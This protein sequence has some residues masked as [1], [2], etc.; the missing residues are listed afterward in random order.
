MRTLLAL[1]A[2]LVAAP[3]LRAAV[4]VRVSPEN[5]VDVQATNAPLSEILD[6]MARQ[7]KIK[8]VYEGPPPRQLLTVD[9]KDRTPAEAFLAVV[10]GQ[11]LAY[12]FAMDKSGTKVE[13]LLMAGGNNAPNANAGP[14]RSPARP[15]RPIRESVVEEPPPSEDAA[16]E[17]EEDEAPPDAAGRPVPPHGRQAEPPPPTQGVYIPVPGADFPSSVF[18]PRP[19]EADTNKPAPKPESTPPPFNP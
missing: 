14:P 17:G 9:L 19:P 10:E 12:A 8:I 7:L 16:A 3:D 13:S 4:Q 18:A 6:G 2:L 15:E 5:R 11:G 1:V